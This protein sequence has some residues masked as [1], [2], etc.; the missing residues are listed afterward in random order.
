MIVSS[1]IAYTLAPLRIEFRIDWLVPEQP[2][3]GHHL[4]MKIISAVETES[5]RTW[6]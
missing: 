6:H 1:S 5:V 3:D 2:L 4:S